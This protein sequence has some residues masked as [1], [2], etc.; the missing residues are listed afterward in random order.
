MVHKIM[1]LFFVLSF[2]MKCSNQKELI[3]Y[4]RNDGKAYRAYANLFTLQW[5]DELQRRFLLSENN[6]SDVLTESEFSLTCGLSLSRTFTIYM[7]KKYKPVLSYKDGLIHSIQENSQ[8][9]KHVY[10][11]V[12]YRDSLMTFY[13]D[14]FLINSSNS[15][16]F[17]SEKK[18]YGNMYLMHLLCYSDSLQMSMDFFNRDFI[19]YN[20]KTLDEENSRREKWLINLFRHLKINKKELLAF[21]Y[22]K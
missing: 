14:A 20:E 19:E 10:E 4:I 21:R 22:S 2:I 12:I 7:Y 1:I 9:Y 16:A 15:K 13:V 11:N 5:D 18:A 17:T 8:S 3:G 6:L